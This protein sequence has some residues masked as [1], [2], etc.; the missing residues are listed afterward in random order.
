MWTA[1]AML[2]CFVG[3]VDWNLPR[4]IRQEDSARWFAIHAATNALIVM[5]CVHDVWISLWKRPFDSVIHDGTA[6][7]S[8]PALLSLV[9]HTYHVLFFKNLTW[10]DWLHHIVSAFSCGLLAVIFDWGPLLNAMIFFLTGLPGG[11]DYLMLLLVKMGKMDSIVE[12]KYNT[13]LNL[14]LRMPGLLITSALTWAG[15]CYSYDLFDPWQWRAACFVCV[16]NAWNGI[17]FC[18]RVVA[19]FYT[20]KQKDED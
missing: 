15:M 19:S 11:I 1:I 17:F 6:A 5:L 9:L 7:S 10:I 4:K 18:H 2:F 14:Y 20:K 3:L 8:T 13:Y 16:A 12:K